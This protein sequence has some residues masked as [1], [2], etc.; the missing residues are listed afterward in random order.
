MKISFVYGTL[1]FLESSK[2]VKDNLNILKNIG[3]HEAKCKS[4]RRN[5]SK[6]INEDWIPTKNSRPKTLITWIIS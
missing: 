1:L 2:T 3:M 5:N 6:R 4:V